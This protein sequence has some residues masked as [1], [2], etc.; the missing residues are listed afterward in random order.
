[1]EVILEL[2]LFLFHSLDRWD[3]QLRDSDARVEVVNKALVLAGEVYAE[4]AT[5]VLESLHPD[6]T[7]NEI[8]RAKVLADHYMKMASVR[9]KEMASRT[10]GA[11]TGDGDGA[12]LSF[13]LNIGGGCEPIPAIDITPETPKLPG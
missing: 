1:M 10:T 7:A 6:A 9:D 13:Y 11:A 3:G 5:V 2:I 12:T 8:N 4:L